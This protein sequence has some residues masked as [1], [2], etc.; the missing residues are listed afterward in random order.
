MFIAMTTV[1]LHYGKFK[2][3]HNLLVRPYFLKHPLRREAIETRNFFAFRAYC[4][5]IEKVCKPKS[6]EPNRLTMAGNILTQREKKPVLTKESI[7]NADIVLYQLGEI[8]P[9]PKDIE[10]IRWFPTTYVYHSEI[11][12]MWQK[13]VSKSYCERIAPLFGVGHVQQVKEL[14]AQSTTDTS[15]RHRGAWECVPGILAS[16]KLEDIGTLT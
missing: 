9:L 4:R 14:V 15:M 7:A 6:K 12:P 16:I 11:Q 2:E 3:L 5:T 10:R 1:L 13:L 8:L